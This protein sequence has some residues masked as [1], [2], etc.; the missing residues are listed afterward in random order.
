M[1][2][3]VKH[4]GAEGLTFSISELYNQI[5]N[6]VLNPLADQFDINNL[7]FRTG[8]RYV[9]NSLPVGAFL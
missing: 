7:E 8:T 9:T 1:S 5:G 6:T 4:F 2:I 3:R